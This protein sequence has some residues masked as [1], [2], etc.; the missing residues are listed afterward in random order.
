MQKLYFTK[1][2][3]TK[4]PERGTYVSAGLDFF[5]PDD[6]NGGEKYRLDTGKMVKVPTGIRVRIPEGYGLVF[7]DKSGVGVKGV[8]VM[9]GVIDEDYQGEIILCMAK[10]ATPEDD[11]YDH[12]YYIEPGKK[13]AQG[14]LIPLLYA[15]VEEVEDSDILYSDHISARG[16][17]GFGSTG[18]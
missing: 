1:E 17:G 11:E 8:K 13:L 6:F 18:A 16:E 15:E 9:A 14:L 7:L 10:V 2:R 5:V 12:P 4:S 3:P